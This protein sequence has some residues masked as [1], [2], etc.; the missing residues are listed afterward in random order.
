ME[1]FKAF[2]VKFPIS[3]YFPVLLSSD[4]LLT[5]RAVKQVKLFSRTK[6]PFG[7]LMQWVPLK[8]G[9]E[10]GQALTGNFEA[11]IVEFIAFKVKFPISTYFPVLFSS[12]TLLTFLRV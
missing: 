3:T 2:K 11:F 1:A 10:E 5:F 7:Q 9:V 6:V 8:T 4:T 12:D